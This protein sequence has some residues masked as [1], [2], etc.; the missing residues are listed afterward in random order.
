MT[1]DF[2]EFAWFIGIFEGEGCIYAR[3]KRDRGV[4]RKP[5][6][7]LQVYMTDEDIVRRVA[8]VAQCGGVRG[9]VVRGQGRKDAWVWSAD[10]EPACLLLVQMFPYLGRRRQKK[11]LERLALTGWAMGND[12]L[13]LEGAA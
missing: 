10:G 13:V 6:L 11:A 12:Q 1:M 3:I 2:D 5:S 8:T 9:P 7:R 4:P